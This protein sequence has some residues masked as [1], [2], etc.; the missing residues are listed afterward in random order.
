MN[1]VEM[2]TMGDLAV[3]SNLKEKLEKDVES[4]KED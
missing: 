3:L 2:P 4:K 1:Q